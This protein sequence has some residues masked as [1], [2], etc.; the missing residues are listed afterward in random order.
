MTDDI[1]PLR[2]PHLTPPVRSLDDLDRHWRSIK[3][4]WGFSQPQLFCQV[5]DA[6]G[7]L[8][9]HMIN[10]EDCPEEPDRLLLGNLMEIMTE[11]LADIAPGGSLAM[12]FA[13]P[14]DAQLRD[15]DRV[16]AR[17]LTDA[18]RRAPIDV[19]PVFLATDVGVRI[20]S[21]D[22]LAA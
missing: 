19:W 2:P 5:F 16:W 8:L 4:P 7:R 14:G 18:G 11:L 21:P 1:P 13:R 10:I 6:G 22:D 17:D 3:G 9:P 15:A 12:M 20:A